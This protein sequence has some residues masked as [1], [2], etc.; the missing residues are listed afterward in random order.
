MELGLSMSSP[1][2]ALNLQGPVP[3]K[4]GAEKTNRHSSWPCSGHAGYASAPHYEI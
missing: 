4:W 1:H 2:M 3:T